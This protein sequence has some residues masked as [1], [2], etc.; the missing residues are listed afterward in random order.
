MTDPAPPPASA[1]APT[2]E[3]V[4]AVLLAT[5][6]L[7]A[8]TAQSVAAIED[9]VTLP[10]FRVL[11][12]IASRGP[13][14]LSAVAQGLGVHPSNATRTCDRLVATGLLHRRDNPQDRRNLVLTLTDEGEKLVEDVMAARSRAIEQVLAKMPARRRRDLATALRSFAAA[15]GEVS[16]TDSWA[17]GWTT[18]QETDDDRASLRWR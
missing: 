16:P 17:L 12:M 18:P 7:V 15:A 3:E 1:G 5:R 11:V 2:A 14:N 9:R 13:L 4:A 6:V 8:V 10:Q